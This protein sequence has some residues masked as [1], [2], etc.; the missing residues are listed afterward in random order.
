MPIAEWTA[1]QERPIDG[2]IG[3]DLVES[4]RV[5]VDMKPGFSTTI[6]IEV[7]PAMVFGFL[8]DPSTASVIDPAVM[9]Y[10]PEGGTMGL[11]IRNH[12]HLRIMGVPIQMTSVTTA[13]EPGQRMEFRS[14]RPARPAV[15]EATHQFEPSRDGTIYTWSMHFIPTGL[16]GGPTAALAAGAFQR[17]AREQ[18]RRV[19]IVLEAARLT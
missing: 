12:I 9:R 8:A 3:F 17:N 14:I 13:W 4:E 11:G 5:H 1:L 18:Q 16:G 19:K 15:G 6:V 7:P 10:D 2:P